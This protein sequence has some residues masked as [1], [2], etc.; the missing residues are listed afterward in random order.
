MSNTSLKSHK[1]FTDHH[2]TRLHKQKGR[3]SL[4]V[5]LASIRKMVS[6]S[7]SLM[8]LLAYTDRKYELA[9]R[10]RHFCG[11]LNGSQH[12]TRIAFS[13]SGGCYRPSA[14]QCNAWCLIVYCLFVSALAKKAHY[15]ELVLCC[16]KNRVTITLDTNIALFDVTK[17]AEDPALQKAVEYICSIKGQLKGEC[18]RLNDWVYRLT[19]TT[20]GEVIS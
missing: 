7:E 8:W 16:E 10:L 2:Q 5:I 14:Q 4:S 13:H 19:L 17:I 18:F 6:I 12:Y 1:T 9:G 15:A 20:E 11:W 3:A